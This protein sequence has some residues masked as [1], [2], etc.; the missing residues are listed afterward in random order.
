MKCSECNSKNTI[1]VRLDQIDKILS[2]K[3]I[4][5]ESGVTSGTINSDGGILNN[6][7]SI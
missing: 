3:G 2:E 4:R 6:L 5:R 7:S 1:P